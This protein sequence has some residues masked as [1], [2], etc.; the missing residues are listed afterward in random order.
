VFSIDGDIP[1]IEEAAHSAQTPSVGGKRNFSTPALHDPGF[2]QKHEQVSS[3]SEESDLQD[4]QKRSRCGAD[5]PR[6]LAP[7][8][9]DNDRT[10]RTTSLRILTLDFFDIHE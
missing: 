3:S 9:G 4:D 1:A 7:A 2:E 8:H 6:F 5:P 10:Q